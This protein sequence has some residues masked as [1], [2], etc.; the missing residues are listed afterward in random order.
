DPRDSIGVPGSAP[1]MA[2]RS[3]YTRWGVPRDRQR[4]RRRN[5]EA[6]SRASRPRSSCESLLH[7]IEAAWPVFTQESRESPVGEKLPSGL[8]GRTVVRLVVGIPDALNRRSAHGT[9]LAIAS[10]YSHA[11]PERRHLLWK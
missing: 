6:S 8:A 2:G 4:I 7:F 11:F 5:T 1:A 3:D 10:M 9:G